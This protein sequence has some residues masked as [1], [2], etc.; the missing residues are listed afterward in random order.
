[1]IKTVARYHHWSPEILFGLYLDDADLF[2][3]EYWYNDTIEVIKELNE[4][5]Q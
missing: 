2:G 5:K 3:L 1:M 4:G